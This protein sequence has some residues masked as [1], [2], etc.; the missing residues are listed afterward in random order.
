M[1]TFRELQD[2]V[3]DPLE[4]PVEELT[5]EEPMDGEEP[6]RAID[7]K[8]TLPVLF[9]AMP[10][11][12][13]ESRFRTGMSKILDLGTEAIP[14]LTM[15]ER[16]EMIKVLVSILNANRTEDMHLLRLMQRIEARR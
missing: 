1:K 7:S 13:D 11:C 16:D 2:I 15:R 14:L 12:D 3:A 6:V 5:V 4:E 10:E 8:V 9:A